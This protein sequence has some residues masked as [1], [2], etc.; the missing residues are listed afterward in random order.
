MS[1]IHKIDIR[2]IEEQTDKLDFNSLNNNDKDLLIQTNYSVLVVS[3]NLFQ[4][5]FNNQVLISISTLID[6]INAALSNYIIYNKLILIYAIQV[7]LKLLYVINKEK[8]LNIWNKFFIN[9]LENE[10][11]P[12]LLLNENKLEQEMIVHAAERKM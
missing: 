10:S 4:N 12:T 6:K 3:I 11:W 9:D 7:S 1:N 2:I 5:K 8:A